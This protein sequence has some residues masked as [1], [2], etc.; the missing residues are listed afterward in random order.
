MS[1]EQAFRIILKSQCDTAIPGITHASHARHN[2]ALPYVYY[3][4]SD[5]AD[6]PI[7]HTLTTLV[8]VQS[9]LNGSHQINDIVHAIR[10][11]MH[12]NSFS[13]NGWH[14]DC[15]RETSSETDFDPTEETW[16]AV[17][18]LECIASEA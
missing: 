5:T 18:R 14:F 4:Q 2:E 3:G 16:H 8:H 15:V 1:P 12:G 6:H 7:G 9:K 17:M 11:A 13:G 10:E